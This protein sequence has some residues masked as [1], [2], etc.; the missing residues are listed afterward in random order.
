MRL[1]IIPSDQIV[2]KNGKALN[3]PFVLPDIRAV[4]WYGSSGEVEY[5]DSRPNKKITSLAPYQS[6]ADAYQTEKTRLEDEAAQ[7][8]A[9][10][11]EAAKPTVLALKA[12]RNDLLQEC[13][14]TQSND[15]TLANNPDWLTYRQEL[16]ALPQYIQNNNIQLSDYAT[17]DL[18]VAA[19]F[20]TKPTQTQRDQK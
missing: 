19:V 20:P 9:D 2:I 5:T 8:E 15:V 10:A 18:F 6:V 1:T 16:R 17:M 11:I 12:L 3:F 13:D 4:Q 14:W 7:N